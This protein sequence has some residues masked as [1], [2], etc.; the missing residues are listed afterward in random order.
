MTVSGTLSLTEGTLYVDGGNIE[1]TGSIYT[2]GDI[3]MLGGSA[4]V[5]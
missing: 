5:I 1:G 2:T 3:T 4:T